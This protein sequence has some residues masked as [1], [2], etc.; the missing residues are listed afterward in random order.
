MKRYHYAAVDSDTFLLAS[1]VPL[2]PDAFL[3]RDQQTEAISNLL[4]TGYRFVTLDSGTGLAVFEKELAQ[5]DGSE[6]IKS[7]NRLT[8]VRELIAGV[9]QAIEHAEGKG[10]RSQDIAALLKQLIQ[11]TKDTL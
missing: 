3:A 11:K 5:K 2:P 10:W 8:V 9:E 4:N 6:I 1:K 7:M